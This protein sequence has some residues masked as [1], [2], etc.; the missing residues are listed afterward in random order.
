MRYLLLALCL[1]ACESKAPDELGEMTKNV[2]K[3]KEGI[4][5]ILKPIAEEKPSVNLVNKSF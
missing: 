5:I 4:E 3:K 2:L 1:C